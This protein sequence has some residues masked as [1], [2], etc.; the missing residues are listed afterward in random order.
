MFFSLLLPSI[1]IPA[2][3]AI[4]SSNGRVSLTLVFGMCYS[5][6]CP[7]CPIPHARRQMNQGPFGASVQS[8]EIS[9]KPQQ[10]CQHP[11]H[12]PGHSQERICFLPRSFQDPS[13]SKDISCFS[14]H[15]YPALSGAEEVQ[16]VGENQNPP[17]DT[18]GREAGASW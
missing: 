3:I 1:R 18:G 11:S 8:F 10:Q 6:R 12:A 2:T 9:K 5:I 17:Q 4:M 14:Q 16:G 15:L 7:Y 13:C